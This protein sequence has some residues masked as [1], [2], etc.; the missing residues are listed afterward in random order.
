MKNTPRLLL[1][2]GPIA[3]A[4]I[5]PAHAAM[6]CPAAP[7][8][9]DTNNVVDTQG[10]VNGLSKLVGG[11]LKNRT[12]ITVTNLFEKY[13]NADRVTVATLIMAQFCQV[14]DHSSQLTDGEKLDRLGV[15]NG[16]V[17]QLMTAPTK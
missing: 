5:S 7:K 16:Q 1:L 17:I 4:L 11:D 15:V 14:I 13:P 8:N 10:S 12:E 2:L 9:V 3:G 6:D